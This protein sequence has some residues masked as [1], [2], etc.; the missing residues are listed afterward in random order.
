MSTEEDPKDAKDP[1]DPKDP[2]GAKEDAPETSVDAAESSPEDSDAS[3]AGDAGDS[4]DSGDAA[5]SGDSDGTDGADGKTGEAASLDESSARQAVD[6]T[7]Y[8]FRQPSRLS[9]V[10]ELRIMQWQKRIKALLPVKLKA[11]IP[12]IACDIST[13]S[14]GAPDEVTPPY[15]M[16]AFR[17]Q[18]NQDHETIFAIYR[19]LALT[20]V[21]AML[22]DKVESLS[23]DRALTLVEQSVFD[24]VIRDVVDLLDE[25]GQPVLVRSEL[26]GAERR[27]QLIRLFPPSHPVMLMNFRWDTEFGEGAVAWIWPQSLA[28]SLFGHEEIPSPAPQLPQLA[29]RLPF[30]LKVRLGRAQLSV[31]QLAR[32][33]PGDVIVLDQAVRDPL[34]AEVGGAEKMHVWPGREGTRQAVRIGQILD[35]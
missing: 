27:T 29:Q 9:P 32:L 22:G 2:E 31:Q 35:E 4:A 10:A 20:M 8:D 14:V 25:S 1:K 13:P 5:D 30:Q 33:K 19:P 21:A 6:G 34:I 17:I 28:E 15:P 24:L 18:V 7:P 23:E 16:L 26:L 11:H 3:E 12:D